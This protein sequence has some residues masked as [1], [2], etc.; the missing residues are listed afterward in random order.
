MA[1]KVDA[2]PAQRFQPIVEFESLPDSGGPGLWH[3]RS[4][5]PEAVP[6]RG[7]LKSGH[8]KLPD[9]FRCVGTLAVNETF[10]DLV[11][12]IEPSVHQIFPFEFVSKKGAPI[13][14]KGP[15]YL[16]NVMQKFDSVLVSKSNIIWSDTL[17]DAIESTGLAKLKCT[18]IEEADEEWLPKDNLT[19]N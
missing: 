6:R 13:P 15:Y 14:G 16:L 2:S 17:V 10:R 3:A 1:Y 12:S 11:E 8:K 7:V 18:H 4:R 5:T 19:P 9:L